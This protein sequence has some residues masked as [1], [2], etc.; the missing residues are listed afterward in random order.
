MKNVFPKIKLGVGRR[1]AFGY[2]L[3]I[4]LTSIGGFYGVFILQKSR[5]IDREVTEYYLPLVDKLEKLNLVINSSEKLINNWVFSPDMDEKEELKKIHQVGFSSIQ[6]D[7]LAIQ[8]IRENE[9]LDDSLQIQ[10]DLINESIGYQKQ[11]MTMLNSYKD[12]DN[13]SIVFA[14]LPI[15]EEEIT[16]VLTSVSGW[17]N[18]KVQVLQ[19]RSNDLIQEKYQSF[20][21]VQT[22]IMSLTLISILLGVFWSIFATRSILKPIKRLSNLIS[23]MARGELPEWDLTTSSDEIGDMT[24]QLQELRNGLE[25]TTSFA[26]KIRNGNLGTDY[27]LLSN[28]DTLGKSLISMR[29]NLKKVINETN[30][31]VKQ[32]ID[33]GK[34]DSQLNL[35][36]KEGAWAE[37]SG[38]INDL[39]DSISIPI[40]SIEK[41]LT[42][43]AQGDLS[44]RYTENSKG[45]IK[46][47][48]DSLNLALQ[49]LGDLLNEILNNAIVID[50]S[51]SEMLSNGEEMSTSTGEIA[52]AISQM[53]HGAQSQVQKV[54][55]S[56]QLVE[57]ILRSSQE[58]ASRSEEIN[59]AAKNGVSNSE[60]GTQIISNVTSSIDEIKG[61]S[62][63]TNESMQVLLQRSSEIERVLGVIT[64]IASQTNL[65]ALNAAIEAAQAGDAGRGFAVVAEEI[66][67]LAEDSRS[68]AKEIESLISAVSGDT[69]KTAQMME[70]MSQSVQKGVEASKE[71]SIV[72]EEMASSSGQTLNHSEDILNSSNIQ[73]EKIKDVVN[74]TESIVV[75]AEQTSAGTEE[76]ASSSTELSAGMTNYIQKSKTLNDISLKLK[77]GLSK[78]KL[79]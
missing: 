68:S 25:R 27:E 7:I 51:T 49:N 63:S 40:K 17:I 3:I 60:K 38:S 42:S 6:S 20:S 26:L 73:S 45:E 64:D 13:D 36:D 55:E 54:D 31:V 74:I 50:E 58:M 65:L 33:Q 37:L 34:L 48:T 56:S 18:K 39:F 47:L 19:V 24:R 57:N 12:Y 53:S 62:L 77:E 9:L 30:E 79:S 44:P 66:R 11:I 1:I 75:I 23:K 70:S 32:V 5:S 67:K 72:F 15:L 21:S 22:V 78:F 69:Q 14:A 4:V 10:L 43:M 59:I 52:S 61:V 71:A 16:P 46:N 41:I 29:D 8:E 76:V 2:A 35:E 28:D